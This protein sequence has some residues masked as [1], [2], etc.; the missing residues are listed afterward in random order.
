MDPPPPA[1]CAACAACGSTVLVPHLRVAGDVGPEGLVP[2]T[3]RFGSALADIVRCPMCSHRQLVRMPDRAWLRAAYAEAVSDAYVREAAGERAS[4]RLTLAA[5]ERHVPAGRLVDLG[6]WVGFLVAEAAAR[7]WWAQ[8]VEPSG[9]AS[10]YA[11]D[12]L[13]LD[14]VTGEILDAD[15]PPAAFDAVVI[16]DVIEHLPDPREAL[17]RVAGLLA[18]GG[19]LHLALPDA[20]SLVAR[21]LGRRWWSVIP[22][23]LHYFT[24]ASVSTLLRRAGWEPLEIGTAP[25]AFSVAYYLGRI[26]GYS[27][28]LARA[29]VGAARA[30]GL[31]ERIWAPDF[32]DR[33]YV[34]ARP[35]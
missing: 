35:D 5:V 21:T 30:A 1:A 26:G 15:L 28:P 22:T 20:G 9:W 16:A 33:M 29:L 8:G 3:D 12:E 10:A 31:A 17:D 6:C 18:P 24:R 2:T 25:K 7:G 13:G 11:R 23:H 34:I 32:H 4:A 14:V 19:V 27:R